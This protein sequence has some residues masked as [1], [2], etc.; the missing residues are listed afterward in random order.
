MGHSDGFVAPR[1]QIETAEYTLKTVQPNLN[2]FNLNQS[3]FKEQV[4]LENIS[5]Y[6]DKTNTIMNIS[7]S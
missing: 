2:P 1:A 5:P 3:N 6:K 7:Q 4:S